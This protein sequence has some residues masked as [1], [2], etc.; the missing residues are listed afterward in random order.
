MYIAYAAHN[1]T[2]YT[3]YAA[4]T[5]LY[6]LLLSRA[7]GRGSRDFHTPSNGLVIHSSP[8]NGKFATPVHIMPASAGN[9]QPPWL[10]TGRVL[11]RAMKRRRHGTGE[12]S[13]RF[14]C[15]FPGCN[16]GFVEKAKYLKHL[17]QKYCDLNENIH[18]IHKLESEDEKASVFDALCPMFNSMALKEASDFQCSQTPLSGGQRPLEVGPMPRHSRNLDS[19]SVPKVGLLSMVFVCADNQVLLQ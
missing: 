18:I 14:T 4:Y 8:H 1:C 11:S 19:T 7:S 12:R 13:Q 6:T 15:P 2:A 17:R 10:R 9:Q 16:I 5:G 3:A